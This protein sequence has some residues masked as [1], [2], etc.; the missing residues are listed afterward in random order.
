SLGA[1]T[2]ESKRRRVSA[3]ARA[4]GD[5]D[6]DADE[7]DDFGDPEIDALAA[8]YDAVLRERGLVDVDELA[9][10][11][12]ELLSSAPVLRQ[13]APRGGRICAIGDPD[14]AIYGFRGGDVGYFLRFGQDFTARAAHGRD[15]DDTGAATVRLSRSYRSAPTIV[16][17]AMQLIRP[18]SLVPGRE[19]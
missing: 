1:R 18:G 5:A 6:A 9:T 10:R 19:L 3:I 2:A 4:A 8:R 16:R 13:L 11:P 15:A 12:V 7:L 14:Q 17:A